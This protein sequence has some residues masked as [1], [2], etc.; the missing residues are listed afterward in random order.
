MRN[1]IGYFRGSF[2]K[3]KQ[4]VI[5]FL[6]SITL[7]FVFVC[8]KNKPTEPLQP[9]DPLDYYPM[10][11]DYSWRYIHLSAGCDANAIHDSFDLTILR[12]NTR[13][14]NAGYDRFRNTD[15]NSI[16]FIFKKAD[17]LFT[18]QVGQTVPF[19]KILVGPIKENTSWSDSNLNYLIQGFENV[20]LAINGV[21]YKRCAKIIKTNRNPAKPNVTYEWWAPSYG[22][23]KDMEAEPSG[24]C[25]QAEELRSFTTPGV[26]P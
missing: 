16:T 11:K 7:I 8:S 15:T 1:K 26:I 19:Y 18:E 20:T 14:G 21:T 23:V 12:A 25:V 9:T 2:I 17:T 24:P 22:K 10:Q 6:L 5:F 3:M 13:H 4:I